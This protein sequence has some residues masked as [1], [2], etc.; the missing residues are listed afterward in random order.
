MSTCQNNLHELWAM[1]NFLLPDVFSS[2][3][4][5]DEWFNPNAE[6]REREDVLSQA[7]ACRCAV[8]VASCCGVRTLSFW[9]GGGQP[10]R[11]TLL[12]W[13]RCSSLARLAAA[14]H[15]SPVPPPPAQG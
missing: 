9:L 3:D 7:H 5:F 15:P 2:A 11:V 1:L 13:R 12:V 8:Y 10:R 14:P 6:E 4:Q